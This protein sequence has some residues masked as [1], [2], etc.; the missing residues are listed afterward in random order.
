MLALSA[1][2]ISKGWWTVVKSVHTGDNMNVE[3]TEDQI[4]LNYGGDEPDWM[5]V[6]LDADDIG[7]LN[8]ISV[9]IDG[10]S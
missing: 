9:T 6:A 2:G 1:G 5:D 10:E 7:T 4:C 8:R 3:L